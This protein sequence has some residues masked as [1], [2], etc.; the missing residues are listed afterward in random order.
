MG[1]QKLLDAVGMTE[2]PAGILWDMD[3]TL[4]D[5]EPEWLEASIAVVEEAGG[6]WTDED[7]EDILGASSEDHATVLARAVE[8]ETGRQVDHW[9]L[10]DN[11]VA[12]VERHMRDGFSLMPGALEMMQ[13]FQ[14][15]GIPQG[16]VT[17]SPRVLVEALFDGID[18]H[19]LDVA[20]TGDDDI[21]GK[22]DP[23]PYRLG[24]ERLGVPIDQ[25]LAFED[26]EPGTAA[27]RDAGAFT[28]SVIDQPLASLAALLER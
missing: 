1:I 21:P 16:L 5:T 13:A 26:S 20:V 2:R 23:A 14:K 22:P 12:S 25:C 19:P 10:F 9:P 24:A 28:V 6:V 11:V 8:R 3:G 18:G 4:I 15:E 17:A 7:A 27:A